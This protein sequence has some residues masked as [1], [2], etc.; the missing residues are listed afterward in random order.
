MTSMMHRFR[1]CDAFKHRLQLVELHYVTHSRA[2]ETSL[3][4]NCVGFP[5]EY[6]IKTTVAK[7]ING[8]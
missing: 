1:D 2:A 3:A 7:A 5:M 6:A 8:V 4:E